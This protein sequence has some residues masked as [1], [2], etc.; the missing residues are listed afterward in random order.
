MNIANDD[1][2]LNDLEQSYPVHLGQVEVHQLKSEDPAPIDNGSKE[3]EGVL[4]G[5]SQPDEDEDEGNDHSLSLMLR[6]G[7]DTPIIGLSLF[8]TWPSG[9]TE[10]LKT[11]SNGVASTVM[12]LQRRGT[13]QLEVLDRLGQKQPVCQLELEQCKSIT[14]VRSPKVLAQLP[15]REHQVK[16]SSSGSTKKTASTKTVEKTA[17]QSKNSNAKFARPMPTPSSV[18][19]KPTDTSAWWESNGALDRAWHWLK[20]V[21]DVPEHPKSPQARGYAVIPLRVVNLAGQPV[22]VIP[23]PECPNKDNLRLGRNNIY[24][25]AVMLAAKRSNLLPQAICAL[26]DCEAAKLE[27]RIPL[28]DAKGQPIKDK[29]GKPV[30]RKIAEVWKAD[31]YNTTSHAGG[32]TQFLR[33]TWLGHVLMPGRYIHQESVKLGWVRQEQVSVKKKVV[34][35]WVFVLSD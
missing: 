34:M 21:L 15:L 16:G 27:E 6:D 35:R 12:P 14:V 26:L 31:S 20:E 1:A 8:L 11:S 32:M 17:S 13:V 4:E 25:E 18:Q 30:V 23:G 2:G 24:R 7:L 28:L 22:S 5:N 3:A 33:S 9:D 19:A 29:R 10:E